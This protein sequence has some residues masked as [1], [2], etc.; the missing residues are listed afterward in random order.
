MI[1]YKN[2]TLTVGLLIII[3]L[4]GLLVLHYQLRQLQIRH[5]MLESLEKQYVQTIR[6]PEKEIQWY[7]KNKELIIDGKLFDIKTISAENGMVT[8][9]GLFDEKETLL[10]EKIHQLQR[11]Q[12]KNKDGENLV[13]KFISFTLFYQGKIQPELQYNLTHII[14]YGLYQNAP[15]LSKG[16]PTPAPPP[17]A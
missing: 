17:K 9:T 8:C 1:G 14:P 6:L 10:K 16:L 13:I 12:Q 5:Q 15:L 3:S 2:K 7:K 11:R 4:P